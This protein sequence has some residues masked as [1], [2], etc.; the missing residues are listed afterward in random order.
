M[1]GV[2]VVLGEPNQNRIEA[3]ARRLKFFEEETRIISEPGFSAAWVGHDPATLFAPAFDP[4]TGVRVI[5]SG[6]VSW[7]E[8]DWKRAEEL[9]GFDGGLSNRLL[10]E[11][12]LAGGAKA[13]HRHDGPAALIVWDPRQKLVHLWTD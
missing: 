13:L 10:L 11:R 12:Y 2:F 6:R 9:R 4:Q 7:D 5:T 3:A 8:P 1:A